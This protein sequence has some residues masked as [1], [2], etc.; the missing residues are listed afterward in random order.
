MR[1][2]PT[3]RTPL[4]RRT[5]S[6]KSPRPPRARMRIPSGREP[7]ARTS[8]ATPPSSPSLDGLLCL[9]HALPSLETLS[10]PCRSPY[11]WHGKRGKQKE[12][13]VNGPEQRQRYAQPQNPPQ[14]GEHRHIHVVEDE[15]LI[16]QHGQAVEILGALVMLD[17]SDRCLQFGHVGLEGDRYLVAKASLHARAHRAEKPCCRCR[18]RK[19]N[20]RSQHEPG[21][22]LQYALA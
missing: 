20:G 15:H 21:A 11:R 1:E 8:V 9:L 16:A 3:R 5:R 18:H 13:R 19:P 12:R 17:R 4:P 2:A 7:R 10:S 6:R 14:H 22:V